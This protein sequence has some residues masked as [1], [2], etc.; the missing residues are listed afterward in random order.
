MT[1]RSLVGIMPGFLLV[2]LTAGLILSLSPSTDIPPAGWPPRLSR[3]FL[4]L[5]VT[6][7]C[8]KGSALQQ[9]AVLFAWI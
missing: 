7:F 1:G 5:T 4:C 2:T 3:S 8:C 9:A 6:P